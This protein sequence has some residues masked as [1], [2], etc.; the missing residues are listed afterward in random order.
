MTMFGVDKFN[1]NSRSLEMYRWLRYNMVTLA[2]LQGVKPQKT[3][4]WLIKD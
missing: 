2:S 3:L 4:E 1:L